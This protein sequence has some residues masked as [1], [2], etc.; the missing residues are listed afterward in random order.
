MPPKEYIGYRYNRIRI[1]TIP[2]SDPGWTSIPQSKELDEILDP[3][4]ADMSYTMNSSGTYELEPI[5]IQ[6]IIPTDRKDI[7]LPC[8]TIS[9]LISLM[10]G[11]VQISTPVQKGDNFEIVCVVKEGEK[12]ITLEGEGDA[13]ISA[14]IKIVK[15]LVDIDYIKVGKEK[16]LKDVWDKVAECPKDWRPGQAVFNIVD[17]EYG[18]AR[19]VKD[20]D[21]IDC[22]YDNGYIDMFLEK[23]WIRYKQKKEEVC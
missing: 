17:S 15:Q 20:E 7:I 11:G 23:A 16:F 21:G 13:L 19:E 9:A 3:E 2:G 10:P 4:T 1:P 22:F 8:W 5:P 12:F 14:C 18:V 6:S